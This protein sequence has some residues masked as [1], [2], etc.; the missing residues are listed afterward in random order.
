MVDVSALN[1]EVVAVALSGGCGAAVAL[2]A[3]WVP[4]G[5]GTCTAFLRTADRLRSGSGSTDEVLGLWAAV[6]EPARM[7]RYAAM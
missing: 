4:I 2:M 6:P 3:L 7:Q 1:L 5:G